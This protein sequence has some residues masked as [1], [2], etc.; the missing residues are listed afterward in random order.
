[1]LTVGVNGYG[2]IGKRVADAVRT[3][4]DMTLEGVAKTRP[5][6]EAERAV[7]KGYPL[8]AAVEERADRF[9]EAGI[10]LA[11]MVGELVERADVMVDATPSGIGAENKPLYEDHDTP[12]LYQGGEDA[13]LDSI[14]AALDERDPYVTL[15]TLV[16]SVKRDPDEDRAGAIATFTGRV[17]A[18]ESPDD[19]PTEHLEFERYDGVA[20]ERMATLRRELEARDGVHAVRLHHKSGVVEAGEDIVFVVVAAVGAAYAVR[21]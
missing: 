21:K 3:Q 19:R 16:A 4:P 17:R 12:A 20:E 9:A 5:N 2:T 18:K 13:D 11:G 14:L 8:Y 10:D 7:A 15:E 6:F 1:M